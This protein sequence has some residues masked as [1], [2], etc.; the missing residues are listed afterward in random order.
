MTSERQRRRRPTDATLRRLYVDQ[1]LPMEALCQRYGVSRKRLRVWL[2]EAGIPIRTRH[3]SG[4][5][6]QLVSPAAGDLRHMYE[7]ERLSSPE[8]AQRLGVSQQTAHRWLTEAGISLRRS[9]LKG[10]KRG[11]RT[12]V[13]RPGADEIARLYIE[14]RRSL[15]DVAAELGATVHLVRTWMVEDGIPRRPAGGSPGR[16][17][18]PLPRRKPPPADEE[19]RRLRLQ[20]SWTLRELAAHFSVH[21][22]TVR[23]WLTEAGIP[24]GH[25]RGALPGLSVAELVERYCA[26]TMTATDLAG[27]T[28]V[29]YWRVVRE[30]RDAGVMDRRRRP[31]L[32]SPAQAAQIQQLYLGQRRTLVGTAEAVGVSVHLVRRQLSTAGV[33]ITRRGGTTRGDRMEAP[34]EEVSQLY[35]D[36]GHSAEETGTVLELPGGVVLRT[37][38]DHG[39]PIRPGG[40]PIIPAE[41]R[42]IETLYSDDEVREVLERH[43]VPRRP[44]IGGIAVRFPVPVPL[45]PSLL[46]DLY[47]TAGCS[48]PQIELLTG[49][50]RALVE[51]RMHQWGIPVRSSHRPSPALARYRRARRLEWLA[52]VVELY[53]RT[54]STAAVAAEF[55]CAQDTVRRW[56][57]EAGVPV[58]GRGRWRR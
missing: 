38:H 18:Q 4:R 33:T 53:Q 35:V 1:D 49:Q 24:P 55:G 39:L 27:Q 20:E 31:Q 47:E 54:H 42:L 36:E 17:R 44:P 52:Q 15:E 23:R 46:V 57:A 37:G 40:R 43:G 13:A 5:R 22:G 10:R 56:L 45:T 21:V 30:L 50:S 26:G 11:E 58:P 16:R 6:R 34:V 48:T 29:G 3:E 25:G 14:Q 9:P 41:V 19:L 32:V 28:G 7:Q 8:I 51:D 12:P 2:V